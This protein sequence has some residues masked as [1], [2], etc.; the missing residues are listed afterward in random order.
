MKFNLFK[1]KKTSDVNKL[2]TTTSK[3]N[4]SKLHEALGGKD[5][6]AGCEYTHKKVKIFI[7]ERDKVKLESVGLIKGI[8]GIFGSKKYITIIVGPSAKDLAKKL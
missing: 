3:I 2:S 5:N 1:K 4:I 6:I 8:S 7:Y